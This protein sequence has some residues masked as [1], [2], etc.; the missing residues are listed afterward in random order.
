MEDYRKMGIGAIF[1]ANYIKAAKENKL[2]GG[3]ASWILENNT[4]MVQAAEKL[5]GQR[6][7]TY[8]IY[9]KTI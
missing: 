3:E 4:E 1:F 5:N 8:R 9:S 2:T 6:Y 7:K